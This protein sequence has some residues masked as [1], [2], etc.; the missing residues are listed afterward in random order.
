MKF[1]LIKPSSRDV[2]LLPK[3]KQIPRLEF[4]TMQ[5]A[6]AGRG[7]GSGRLNRF[8]GDAPPFGDVETAF[9]KLSASA[10]RRPR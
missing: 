5:Q 4:L 3:G 1:H 8:H 2:K 6:A 7:R 10:R 9:G